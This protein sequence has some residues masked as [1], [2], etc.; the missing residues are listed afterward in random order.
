MNRRQFINLGGLA[1]GALVIWR[2]SKSDQD[3]IAM[4]LYTR[5]DYLKLDPKGV[6]QFAHELAARN[7]LSS[8]RLHLLDALGPIYRHMTQWPLTAKALSAVHHGEERIVTQYL[9]GSDFFINGADESRVVHFL[10]MLDPLRACSNPFARPPEG[11][12]A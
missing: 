11:I 12:P 2:L 3:A 1:L 4:M 9:I 5:L 7:E 10:G 8:T 6:R